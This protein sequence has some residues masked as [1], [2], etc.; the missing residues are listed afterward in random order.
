MEIAELNFWSSSKNGSVISEDNNK[1][2]QSKME[3]PT[4]ETYYTTKVVLV[5]LMQY[6]NQ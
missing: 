4:S 5:I 6:S 3:M 1:Y 2:T